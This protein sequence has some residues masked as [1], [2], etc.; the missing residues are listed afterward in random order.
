MSD[1]LIRHEDA[2]EAP[3]EEVVIGSQEGGPV[4]PGDAGSRA[5]PS[6]HLSH[7]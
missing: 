2:G 3:S 4:D 6:P 7:C 1:E 5:Q